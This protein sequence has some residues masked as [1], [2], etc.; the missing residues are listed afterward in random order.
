MDV[1]F[2][3]DSVNDFANTPGLTPETV[4]LS[5]IDYDKIYITGLHWPNPVWSIKIECVS[6]QPEGEICVGGRMYSGLG[7]W[8]NYVY[9]PD[10]L[11]EAQD[12]L[13]QITSSLLCNHEW[14]GSGFPGGA[15]WC[16]HCDADMPEDLRL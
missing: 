14:T 15:M 6:H 1:S 7:V 8:N 9:K 16:K 4:Y 11:G 3:I 13:N 5:K 2:I 12:K 10:P